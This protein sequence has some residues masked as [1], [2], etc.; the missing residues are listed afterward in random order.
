M[1]T[2]DQ[3]YSNTT[4]KDNDAQRRVNNV[5]AEKSATTEYAANARVSKRKLR[6]DDRRLSQPV[7]MNGYR[8]E[9]L[10]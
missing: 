5:R 2:I 10:S 9:M 1:A 3:L 8:S 7:S 4:K 6:R